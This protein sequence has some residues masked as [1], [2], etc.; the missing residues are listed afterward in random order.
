QATAAINDTLV[1]SAAGQL[2]LVNAK[3]KVGAGTIVDVR[4][5]EVEL[6][7]AQ[8][9]AVTAHNQAQVAKLQLFQTMGVAGNVDAALVTQFPLTQPT[10]SLDSLI[11][12]AHHVNPDLAA[13]Q[14]RLASSEMQVKVARSQYLP[15]LSL[16]T[17]YGAQ[18]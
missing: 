12:L 6:G 8:V 7:Q 11:N 13:R 5:A 2:E 3:M 14:S 9:A 4:T 1:L 17:G 16:S 15:S 18:A 10:F